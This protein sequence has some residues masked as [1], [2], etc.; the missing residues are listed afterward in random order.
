MN[1]AENQ[2]L[3][4]IFREE[5]DEHVRALN[6]G[7]LV[8]ERQPAAAPLEEMLRSAH[9][10][11]GAARMLGCQ[12]VEAISHALETLLGQLFRQERDSAPAVLDGLYRGVDAI[13]RAVQA[14]ENGAEPNGVADLVAEIRALGEGTEPGGGPKSQQP[15][16]TPAAAKSDGQANETGG[17]TTVRVPTDKLDTLITLAGELLVSKIESGD[18]LRQVERLLELLQET[19]RGGRA[20]GSLTKAEELAK[21]IYRRMADDTHRAGQVIDDLQKEVRDLR[22]L[23]LS[24]ILDAFPRMTRD[25]ARETGKEVDLALEGT[26]TCL[27][28]KILEEIREPLIHL[29]RNAVAHGVE[30]PAARAR[31]GKKR[32]GTIT[33]A[34]RQESGRVVIS[35]SDDGKGLDRKAIEQTAIRCGA[36]T[37]EE[38]RSWRDEEV[39]ELVFKS[40]FSTAPRL[41]E[42]AG[43][44]VGL[45]AVRA[46]VES[47]KGIVALE[48]RAGAGTT[49]VLTLP[50][51]LSTVHALFVRVNGELFCLPTEALEQTLLIAPEQIS[52]VEGKAAVVIGGE[53]L[54]YAWLADIL[55]L[56]RNDRPTIPALLLRGAKGR[57]VI[58]VEA[59]VG[60]EKVVAKPLGEILKKVPYLAG[61][62]TLGKGEIALILSPDD[63]LQAVA[64]QKAGRPEAAA[65]KTIQPRRKKGVILVV[66]DSLT[67][68]SLE[69]SILETAGYDVTTAVDGEDALVQLSER[70]F[71]LVISDVQMPRLDGFALTQKIKQDNRWKEIPVILVTSLQTDQDRKKGI[72]AGADAYLTKAAFDQKQLLDII[73]RLL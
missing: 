20:A 34:A 35:V 53:T 50:L 38:M 14:V 37:A 67:T 4:Q 45:D 62:T 42:V 36:A 23:P 12:P 69:K 11:K 5:C 7:L 46:K 41:T 65:A 31:Q 24:L 30:P 3:W 15:A 72:E 54:A 19:S 17:L 73:E 60:E 2:N 27:D 40:G 48:S 26:A 43:R 59:L 57:A 21:K 9:S 8:L 44:G 49:C 47:L 33:I 13:A 51:M 70:G 61:A 58:G 64:R 25:L 52:T 32:Q 18:Q 66:E 16:R 63:V 1:S 71:D 39:W 10:L 29:V 68:R 56:P 6:Q 28:K 55:E 22:L